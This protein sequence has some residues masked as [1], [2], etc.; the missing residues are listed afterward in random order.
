MLLRADPP[1]S[2][3]I[4]VHC[5]PEF[6]HEYDDL[7][8]VEVISEIPSPDEFDGEEKT[9]VILD[10]IDLT[11]LSKEQRGNL[12]RLYGFVSTHCNVSV[13]LT[14][15]E[16]FRVP[17]IVRRCANYYVIWKVSDTDSLKMIG[18]KVGFKSEDFQNIFERHFHNPKDSLHI[19]LT[20]HSPY[21]LRINGYQ[22]LKRN[23]G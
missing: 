7:D 9:M 4:V 18:R 15:Q 17:A 20:E 22:M 12:D 16:T 2:K 11:A 19:D 14:S 23:E 10:D 13:C 5:S 3:V 21:P 8:D 6:T 1:F